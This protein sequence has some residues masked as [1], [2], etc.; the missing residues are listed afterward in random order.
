[1]MLPAKP[2]RGALRQIRE[3]IA[4]DADGAD[5]ATSA[6]YIKACDRYNDDSTATCR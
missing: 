6:S 1:M 2:Q 3:L 5:P 4:A